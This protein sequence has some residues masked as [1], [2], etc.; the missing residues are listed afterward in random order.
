MNTAKL[1]VDTLALKGY[2]I[3]VEQAQLAIERYLARY[4]ILTEQYFRVAFGYEV[5]DAVR[6]VM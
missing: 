4:P 6:E 2:N 3:T 1:V 5:L